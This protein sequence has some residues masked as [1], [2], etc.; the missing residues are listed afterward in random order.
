MADETRALLNSLDHQRHHV[1]AILEGLTD[2]QLRRPNLPSAWTCLGLVHHLALDVEH[3]WFRCIT[4]GESLDFFKDEAN[5]DRDAWQVDPGTSPQEVFDLYRAEIERSNAI[6]ESTPLDA[7]PQLLDE[8]WGS[9]E[10]PDLRFI[11]LHVI[12][13][14]ACHAGHLDAAREL[15]DHRQWITL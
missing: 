3:Y 9:W 4:A 1:Q 8:W 2:E 12:A 14:T 15:I 11:L 13:E 5:S 7:P 10:V 6:V